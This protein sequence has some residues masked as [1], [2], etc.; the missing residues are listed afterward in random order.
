MVAPLVGSRVAVAPAAVAEAPAVGLKAGVA[1]ARGV[2]VLGATVLVAA[3]GTVSVEAARPGV[4]V[5]ARG[6]VEVGAAVAGRPVSLGSAVAGA[7]VA[8]APAGTT[9]GTCLVATALGWAEATGMVSVGVGPLAEFPPVRLRPTRMAPI[10]RAAVVRRATK[11]PPVPRRGRW[12][13]LAISSGV[14]MGAV[15]S[16]GAGAARAAARWAVG[17]TRAVTN[18]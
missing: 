14:F 4:A 18:S 17:A 10:S 8:V 7:V 13:V 11:A 15:T 12:G 6:L 5:F 3:G 2:A 1:V 16:R 9:T